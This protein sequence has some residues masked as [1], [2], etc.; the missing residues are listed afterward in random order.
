[1]VISSRHLPMSRRGGEVGCVWDGWCRL[2][3]PRG[4][5]RWIGTLDESQGTKPPP[6]S[7]AETPVRCETR[8]TECPR[9]FE[10][11]LRGG[12]RSPRPPYLSREVSVGRRTRRESGRRPVVRQVQSLFFPPGQVRHNL[13]SGVCTPVHKDP[14]CTTVRVRSVI[15]VG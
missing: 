12:E 2:T 14:W 10:G 6:L 4:T 13:V 7:P 9:V 8:K 1:M 15:V 11:L 3:S 5:W